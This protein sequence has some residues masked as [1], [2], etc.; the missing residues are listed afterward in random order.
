MSLTKRP[1]E[2]LHYS[3]N[4]HNQIHQHFLYNIYTH[5]KKLKATQ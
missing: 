2:N 3:A 4:E 5:K 1:A